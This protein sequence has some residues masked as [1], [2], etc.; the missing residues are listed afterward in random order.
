MRIIA[1]AAALL[2]A[3]TL[4][5]F[6]GAGPLHGNAIAMLAG[7]YPVIVPPTPGVLSAL[8]F[9]Y[10]DVKNEFAQ[11]FIRNVDDVQPA[12]LQGILSGLGED[13]KTWLREEGIALVRRFDGEFPRKYFSE[14]CDYMGLTEAEALAIIEKWRNH[15]VWDGERLRHEIS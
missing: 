13:A 14:A 3:F 6:G 10:S 7:C 15:E 4:V 12:Q 1:A 2:G 8:G 5:A 9:L 11:T